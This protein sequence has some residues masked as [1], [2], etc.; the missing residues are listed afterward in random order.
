M[1]VVLVI[2]V[3]VGKFGT[4]ALAGGTTKSNRS[5]ATEADQ[6]GETDPAAS[7]AM[8]LCDG[9]T[10]SIPRSPTWKPGQSGAMAVFEFDGNDNPNGWAPGQEFVA[11][12]P[13]RAGVATTISDAQTSLVLCRGRGAQELIK[14]CDFTING[15]PASV[16]YRYWKRTLTLYEARTGRVVGKTEY[17]PPVPPTCPT[18]TVF[19]NGEENSGVDAYPGDGPEKAIVEG[20]T[21]G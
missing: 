3:A 10:K 1:L 18:D 11:V 6:A 2:A 16:E 21:N 4:D 8:G 7:A 19:Q 9:T 17:G 13:L 12:A 14:N 5:D 20:W 15:G